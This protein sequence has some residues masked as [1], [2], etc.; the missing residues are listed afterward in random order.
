MSIHQV[1]RGAEVPLGFAG[2]W[3]AWTPDGK[4]PLA[5]G[6]SPQEA[7]QAAEALGAVPNANWSASQGIAYEWVPPAETRFVGTNPV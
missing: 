7:R 3:V 4:F 5:A 6:D 2:K 1:K